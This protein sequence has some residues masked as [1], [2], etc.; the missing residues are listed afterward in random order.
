MKFQ[1]GHYNSDEP[2]EVPSEDTHDANL[3]CIWDVGIQPGYKGK[4]PKAK[5]C[6]G[7][8]L[9]EKDS[10]GRNFLVFREETAS[11]F[12][13]DGKAANLRKLVDMLRPDADNGEDAVNAAGGTQVFCGLPCRVIVE[14]KNGKARAS[15][16]LKPS[17]AGRDRRLEG[18][19]SEDKP[20]GLAA[21]MAKSAM[22]PSQVEAAKARLAEAAAAGG[23]QDDPSDFGGGQ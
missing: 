13:R 5:V 14:H 4:E 6:I 10:K 21:W 12:K 2:R 19:Y 20:L 15:H 7:F 22:T 9:A 23:A 11:L 8:E 3:A 17:A 1:S 18:Q 16:V